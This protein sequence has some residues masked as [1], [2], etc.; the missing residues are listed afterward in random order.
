MGEDAA[1][2]AKHQAEQKIV[3]LISKH[4]PKLLQLLVRLSRYLP[5]F[6][7]C[8]VKVCSKLSVLLAPLFAGL[9][10]ALSKICITFR[11]LYRSPPERW[12]FQYQQ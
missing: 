6:W 11:R 5:S 7:Q 2:Q 9:F 12:L 10:Y 4:A 1:A 3:E 8:T